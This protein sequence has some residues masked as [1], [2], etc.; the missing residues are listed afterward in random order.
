MF[1]RTELRIGGLLYIR[2]MAVI[3]RSF[4][5]SVRWRTHRWSRWKRVYCCECC[6]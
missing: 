3:V 5:A 1:H 2:L 6:V 4:Y